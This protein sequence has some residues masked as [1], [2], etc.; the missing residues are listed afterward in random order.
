MV[1]NNYIISTCVCLHPERFQA[2]ERSNWRKTS[3]QMDNITEIQHMHPLWTTR[4]V[5]IRVHEGFR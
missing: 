1:S 5:S 2:A 4:D 3:D